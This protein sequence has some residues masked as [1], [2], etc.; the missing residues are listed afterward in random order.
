MWDP[1]VRLEIESACGFAMPYWFAVAQ[2]LADIEALRRAGKREGNR[3]RAKEKYY[4]D[5][6]NPRKWQQKM[7]RMNQRSK[8][9]HLESPGSTKAEL[10]RAHSQWLRIKADPIK[11]AEHLDRHRK[12][13]RRRV[14]AK[15]PPPEWRQCAACGASFLYVHGKRLGKTIHCSRLCKAARNAIAARYRARKRAARRG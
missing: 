2:K 1:I 9:R 12:S 6:A 7:L 14:A 5:K 13:A 10:V 3:R 8:M 4:R 11:Y 15:T